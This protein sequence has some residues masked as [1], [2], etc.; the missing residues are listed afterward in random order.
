MNNSV[1]SY[2]IIPAWL[3]QPQV[4]PFWMGLV[5]LVISLFGVFFLGW[6]L[7]PVIWLLWFEVVFAI[8][9]ALIRSLFAL[10]GQTFFA[11]F[12][13]RLF[14]TGAGAVMGIAFIMLTVTFTING[15]NT[16]K[17]S[18]GHSNIFTPS[19]LL[20]GNYVAGLVFHFFVNGRFKTAAP[21]S[22]LMVTFV[23]I[24]IILALIMPVTMHLLPK[25]PQLEQ[26]KWVGI[27]VV[28][29]KFILDTR[30][31]R[32]SKHIINKEITSQD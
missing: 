9:A 8:G 31:G 1:H 29:I 26:A 32:L 11:R 25:Y 12:F 4:H 30:L 14:I 2:S 3:K 18:A 6:S 21:I 5:S 15:I 28:M 20:F 23:R 24:L 16:E 17:G 13:F 22:E 27:T 19:M 7:E 10:E